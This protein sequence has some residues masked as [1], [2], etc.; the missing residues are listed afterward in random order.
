MTGPPLHPAE[1]LRTP[2]S[3]MEPDPRTRTDAEHFSLS[4]A[5][6]HAHIAQ[7][8][9]LAWSPDSPSNLR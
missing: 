7:L 9:L 4:L 2:D 6:Q 3:V 8:P 5:A 1:A